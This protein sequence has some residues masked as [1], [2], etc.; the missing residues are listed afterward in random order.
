[1]TC[2]GAQ[3]GLR[4]Y[5]LHAKPSAEK[6]VT[7]HLHSRL[8]SLEVFVPLIEVTRRRRNHKW[9][10]LEP[11]FPGY[12]FAI[13]PPEPAAWTTVRW[14][15]GVKRILG[16]GDVPVPVPDEFI[17]KIKSRMTEFGFIRLG[18]P[19]RSGD[20]VRLREGPFA[21]LE[22]IFERQLSPGGRVRVF[23]HLLSRFTPIDVD[24]LDLEA[25]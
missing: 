4:W 22:G 9:N 21:D 16:C 17:D 14:T 13:I 8:R 6:R 24:V 3:S 23:F 11:L 5:V 25:F 2:E 19:F 1:M 7:F 10:R 20:R 15:P 12:L 18:T